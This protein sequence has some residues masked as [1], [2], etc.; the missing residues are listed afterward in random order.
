LRNAAE[1]ILSRIGRASRQ[2][3]RKLVPSQ[4][5]YNILFTNVLAKQGCNS[6][7]KPVAFPVPMSIVNF[8]QVIQVQKCQRKFR[9]PL[10]RL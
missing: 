6:S 9:F 7:D 8:F 4:P 3:D 2:D 5:A 1:D 10:L